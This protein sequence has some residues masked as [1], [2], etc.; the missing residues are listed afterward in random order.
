MK[1]IDKI[2]WIYIKDR[3]VLCTKSK[4]KEKFYSPGGKRENGESD[5][6]TLIREVKEEVDVQIRQD[7]IEYYDTF[8]AQADGKKEG[9]I[10]KMTCY[11]AQYEGE[12]KPSS[13]IEEIA[14]LNTRDLEKLSLAGRYIFEDLR[15][16]E[17]I[18]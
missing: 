5:K 2:A 4:G 9:V 18:D 15:K 12:L 11:T 16:K 8:E 1:V 13:E 3:K 14:F 17:L 10:V 6:E 7:T